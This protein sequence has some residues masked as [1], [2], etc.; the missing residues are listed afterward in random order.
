MKKA[1]V[2]R[3]PQPLKR[4]IKRWALRVLGALLALP[5]VLTLLYTVVPPYSSLMLYRTVTG[6]PVWRKWVPLNEISVN[7]QRSVVVSEDATFCL[8]GGVDWPAVRG[9]V[10]KLFD[11]K[12]PRG[13]STITMQLAKNLFLWNGRDYVRKAL[14]VPL[15]LLLDGVLSKRRLLEIYLNVA[16][17]GPGIYGAEAASET[18][19]GKTAAKLSANQASLLATAL[20]N[21]IARNPAKPASGHRRLAGINRSRAQVAGEVLNCISALE[22]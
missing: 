2:K 17:W 13:A 4:R 19:F 5:V 11:G 12:R 7:L 1:R 18:F 22:R 3:T 9:Q 21:P 15:A 6:Q 10:G 8:H 14:E 16:E 20:P